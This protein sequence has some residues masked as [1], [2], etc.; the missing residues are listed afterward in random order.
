[1]HVRL[2][3]F[4]SDDGLNVV[5]W[6]KWAQGSTRVRHFDT[7]ASMIATL[8]D[9]GLITPESALSLEGFTFEDSCPLF[10]AEVDDRLLAKHGFGAP[11]A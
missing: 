6:G 8:Q 3:V 5:I 2:V 1:M 10:S 9:L 11:E 4:P 7:R